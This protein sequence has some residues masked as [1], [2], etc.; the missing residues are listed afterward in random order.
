MLGGGLVTLLS[1]GI[2]LWNRAETQGNTYEKGR[3]LLDRLADDLRSTVV[4]SHPGADN[5][6]IRFVSDTDDRGRQR[7]RLVRTISGETEHSILR[8]GGRYL[9]VK[10]PAVY[11]GRRDAWEA[12]SGLLGAP[13]GLMEVFYALDPRPGERSLW[14]G[15]RTPI[16]GIG[17]LFHDRNI[18][19][20]EDYGALARARTKGG[21][22]VVAVKSAEPFRGRAR[23]LTDGVLYL[24]FAFW[25]PTTNTWDETQVAM[26]DP[27]P[28]DKSG[29]LFVW[30]S[31]R[32]LLDEKGRSGEFTFTAEEGSLSDAT[33]DIFPERVEITLAIRD[34]LVSRSLYLDDKI[35]SSATRLRL[36][37]AV[38]LPDT[39]R[40]RF[41]LVDEEWI[42]VAETDGREVTVAKKGRGAR[43]TKAVAHGQGS[44][45]EIG[46]T[47]RRLV[48][49][50]GHR[51]N[52]VDDESGRRGLGRRR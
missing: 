16:G 15:V 4:R 25:G 8:D 14:R 22:T 31:T 50:P 27:G 2:G 48:E 1:H 32:A 10:S 19:T 9:S 7:L 41:I 20:V 33:D 39:T 23:P 38:N 13:G 29:P 43:G 3:V 42:A 40:D 18:D 34:E 35:A 28:R 46:T 26:R 5:A 47:F 12:R 44:T 6:W 17:S 36:S 21:T 11:D 52:R 24:G 37:R 30:D 49:V 51:R 45:V